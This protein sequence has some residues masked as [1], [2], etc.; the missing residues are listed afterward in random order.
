M[1]TGRARL[2][3]PQPRARFE[4]VRSRAPSGTGAELLENEGEAEDR[5]YGGYRPSCYQQPARDGSVAHQ[6]TVGTD[7]EKQD[8]PGRRGNPADDACDE[9]PSDRGDPAER[10]DVPSTAAVPTTP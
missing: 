4:L 1:P 9:Q 7:S 6:R 2:A 10:D 5:D 8:Q 3:Q